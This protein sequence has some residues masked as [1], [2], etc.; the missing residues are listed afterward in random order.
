LTD[1]ETGNAWLLS[2]MSELNQDRY[3]AA[4]EAFDKAQHFISSRQAARLWIGQVKE[5][6]QA[7]AS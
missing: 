2:G 4:I 7:A 3:S 6:Q 1:T 5:R